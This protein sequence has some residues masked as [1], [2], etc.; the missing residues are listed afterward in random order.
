[1]KVLVIDIGGTNVKF[2]ATG[3]Q[4]RRKFPSGKTL[5][6]TEM[7]ARVTR[8]TADWDYD[9]L[10]IG[11]PGIIKEGRI[12]TDPKNLGP[13]WIG[14]DFEAAFGKPVKLINDAAMQAI[15]SYQGGVMLF[16]GLGTGLGAALIVAG[17]VVPMELGRLSYRNGTF[18]DYLGVR[19]LKR[20]GKK[21]WRKHAVLAA[22]RLTAAIHL[23]DMVFGGGNAEHLTDLPPGCRVGG[24]ANAFIGGFRMWEQAEAGPHTP[25]T[26]ARPRKKSPARKVPAARHAHVG[27]TEETT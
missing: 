17:T 8:D 10:S 5:T 15:G 7:V 11:Y 18:E 26:P 23:D 14:F 6:P 19:G 1:M 21:K 22:E 13:G 9:A 4:E 2:R 12:V 3:H 27:S 24:N 16:L 25:H 20:L